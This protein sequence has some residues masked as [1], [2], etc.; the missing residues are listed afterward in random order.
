MNTA[1]RAIK[2]RL[3]FQ[4]EASFG[5]ISDRR[6]CWAPLPMR[7][8]AIRQIVREYV[9]TLAAVCPRDGPLVS[10]VMPWL[11]SETT[12]VFLERAARRFAGEFL[13]ML[14]DGAAWHRANNLRVAPNMKLLPLPPY[15]PERNPVEHIW[16]HLR[17]NTFKNTDFDSLDEVVDTLCARLNSP[18]ESPE[19]VQS[20]TC[21]DWI[22]PLCMT[23]N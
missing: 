23:E 7:P 5:R 10:R 1:P 16:N 15:S 13:V 18:H 14:L 6:R 4:D 19:I 9:H 3:L 20:M 17:E 8:A 22:K 2:T 11:D 21:F 12:S